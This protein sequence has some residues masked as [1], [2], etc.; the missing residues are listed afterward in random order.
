M[1]A[2]EDWVPFDATY[3][4]RRS[5]WLILWTRYTADGFEF[6]YTRLDPGADV[7]ARSLEDLQDTDSTEVQGSS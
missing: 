7:P 1:I 5:N 6:A 4:S 2:S 3:D